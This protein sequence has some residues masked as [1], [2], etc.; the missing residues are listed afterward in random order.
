MSQLFK[1]GIIAAVFLGMLGYVVYRNWPHPPAEALGK[2][3]G[4]RR[5]SFFLEEI[6]QKCGV[7]F[8]HEL[9]TLDPKLDHIPPV[10]AAMNASVACLNLAGDGLLDFYVVNSKQGSKNRLYRNKGDG[11]FEDVAE[12]MNVA[13]LNQPGTGICTGAIWADYDNDGYPDLLVY[14]WGKPELFHN[15][16]GKGFKRV[17]EGSGLPDWV[18]ANAACWLD[19]DRD[20]LPDLFIAGYWPDGVNLFSNLESTK[21]MPNSFE[22]ATNGGRKYLLRNRGDGRFEDVTEK[23]GIK[24]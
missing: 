7:N 23:M 5:Y 10:L 1:Q 16:K 8:R 18:Y 13:D 24:S 20:G 9:P 14:K 17:T 22:Y 12:Q 6:A 19:Y 21:M 11:T 4:L 2:E 3:E 15:E